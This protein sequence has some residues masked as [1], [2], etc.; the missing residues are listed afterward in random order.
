MIQISRTAMKCIDDRRSN[1]RLSGFA[2]TNPRMNCTRNWQKLE[3]IGLSSTEDEERYA[4]REPGQ[5]NVGPVVFKYEKYTGQVLLKIRGS[6]IRERIFINST[7]T[8]DRSITD[9][10][11]QVFKNEVY[12]SLKF[13]FPTSTLSHCHKRQ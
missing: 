8:K 9:W 3:R 4:P 6:G 1:S 5:P 7:C 2:R 11:R 13:L 12:K 10:H